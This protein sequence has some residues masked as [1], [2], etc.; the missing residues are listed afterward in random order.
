GEEI[1]DAIGRHGE[2]GTEATD[3]LV[4][5]SLRPDNTMHAKETSQDTFAS[6]GVN[7]DIVRRLEERGITH[8]FAI[9]AMVIRDGLSGRD[10]LGKAKTGSGK[11]L[12]FGIPLVQRMRPD[13]ESAQALVLVPTRELAAQV[14]EELESIAP[15]GTSIVAAYGGVGLGKHLKE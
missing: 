2:D 6:L 13:T 11:T 10:M 7:D 5:R 1:G 9:Q 12:A 15:E 4:E 3:T 14:A 8:P